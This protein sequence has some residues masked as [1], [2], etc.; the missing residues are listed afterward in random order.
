[1]ESQ[2]IIS[3]VDEPNPMV[4]WNGGCSQDSGAIHIFVEYQ[5]LNCYVCREIYT[6]PK[7]DKTLAHL[8]GAKIFNKPDVNS[9]FWHIPLM[10]RSK[11]LTTFITPLG[12]YYMYLQTLPFTIC[13]A[14][15]HFQKWM[16]EILVGL[17]GVLCQMDNVYVFGSR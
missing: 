6:P 10:E 15:E 17:K 4:C 3:K 5:P 13:C 9:G 1:M 14:I 12:C 16:S 11:L 2:G 8:A 7:V